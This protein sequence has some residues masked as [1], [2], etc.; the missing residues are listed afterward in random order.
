MIKDLVSET[1][2]IRKQWNHIPKVLK[3]QENPIDLEF[4]IYQ[5]YILK[6]KTK[7]FSDEQTNSHYQKICLTVRTR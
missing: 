3:V 7:S 5:N 1:M 4:Y 6:M 2:W